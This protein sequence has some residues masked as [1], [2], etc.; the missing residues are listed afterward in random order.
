MPVPGVI[1]QTLHYLIGLRR[2]GYRVIYVE[3]HART[4]S[5]FV[6]GTR[7]S[8]SARAARF[9]S[10]VLTPYGLGSH[11]AFH[12]LHHDGAVL[13]MDEG[14]LRRSYRSADLLLNLCG[15]T[16]PRPEHV[17][18]GRL[19]LVITDPVQVEI[20][21]WQKRPD[22]RE[23]LD[24]HCAVFSYA[25]NYGRSGCELPV[26]PHYVPFPTRQPVILDFW[27]HQ[28]PDRGTYTTV[29]NWRQP[30]RTLRYRKELYHWSKHRE[31]AK[32]LD[33]PRRSG[34]RFELALASCEESDVA[35]LREHGWSVREAADFGLQ[36]D[37]YRAFIQS[38][39]GEFTV[40]KDQNIRFRSGW[41]SDRSATYLASGRPVVT[42]DTGFGEVLPTGSGVFAVGDV[43]GAAAALDA[44]EADYPAA[45]RA[46]HEVAR[47]WFDYRRVLPRMLA[48]VGLE[49]PSP[50]LPVGAAPAADVVGSQPVPDDLVIEPVSRRP[51]QLPPETVQTI[52]SRPIPEAPALTSPRSGSRSQRASIIVLTHGQLPLTRLC[53]ESLLVHTRE[54]EF[55][56]I[57]VDNASPDD[58]AAYLEELA[59]RDRRVRLILN[60]TN[61][62]FAA[63]CNQGARIAQGEV[64]VFLNNDTVVPPG[65]L[66]ALIWA[67]ADRS[68]GA[69]NPV[70]NRSGTEAAV[71]V[72]TGRTYGAFLRRAA[73]RSSIFG[74]SLRPA[75]M[76]AFFCL[77]IRRETWERIGELDEAYGTGLFE[78]DDYSRRLLEAGLRLACAEGVLVHHFGEAS[79]GE[80]VQ[81]GTYGRLHERNRQIF[82]RKW[83]S[84]GQGRADHR[85]PA[86]DNLLQR[87]NAEVAEVLPGGAR[88]AVISRGDEQLLRLGDADGWHFP[89]LED[90]TYAG[91]YPA[92][93]GAA[94]Q[95]LETARRHGAEYLLVPRTGFWWLEHYGGLA[96]HL[97]IAG[98]VV[99]RS[100]DLVLY[101]LEGTA[102]RGSDVREP[103][104]PVAPSAVASTRAPD[105]SRGGGDGPST[106]GGEATATWRHHG[107][108]PRPV[109]IIGS[110]RSGTSVLTWALGQHPNLYPLEETVWFAR[111]HAGALQAFRIGS[112]RGERSQL[113]AMRIERAEFLGA[114]GDAVHGLI[115]RHRTWPASM[116]GPE[117]AYA[118]ARTPHDPKERWVD[119]TPENSFHVPGITEL[120]PEA[121]FIHLLRRPDP[122]VRSLQRF[123]TIGGRRHAVDEAYRKWVAHVRAALEAERTLGPTR[124]LRVLHRDL[125]SSPEAVVRACLD[126]VGE[127]YSPDCLLPLG[128]RINSSG[129]GTAGDDRETE[130]PDP[131]LLEEARALEA[132][133]FG[134]SGEDS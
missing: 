88:V 130:K 26:S 90:G 5:M 99:R 32:F 47:G 97:E 125:S 15:G 70:T 2:L 78:D 43:D 89:R 54:P 129:E 17:E 31:F 18:T 29:A 13:G 68:L 37:S 72:E 69:V 57:V 41:F 98:R 92:D 116:L 49:G 28:R 8:G 84:E 126:F 65:W 52:L 76:L 108:C 11:W 61:E 6:E 100:E 105:S 81:E 50:R 75:S 45:C 21:L 33:L 103:P 22:T 19:A 59:A 39:R 35:L 96:R 120:F 119:G 20:E 128:Q 111:F 56:V 51:L 16:R 55:E 109:F 63:G 86:Y 62:G 107:S 66:G 124:V 27:Q 60:P 134:D 82:Q 77:A 74:D 123:D 12:A 67:L 133:L 23:F 44:I 93:D 87:M 101:R 83:G 40:A 94:V 132:E 112:S 10:D 110:P 73:E 1:W 9:I 64:L 127:A 115:Q 7:D 3:A 91:H 106:A 34:R 25:E 48:E 113:S 53:L 30:L 24:A 114:L 118:R 121:T 36:G 14:A 122:V 38:S 95:E 46:A 4:P 71:G 80:L 42:Q 79:F 85:D 131:A 58:T 104:R 102:G 117:Q